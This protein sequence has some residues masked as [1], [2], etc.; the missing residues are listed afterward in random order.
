MTVPSPFDFGAVGNGT[1]DDTAALQSWIEVLNHAEYYNQVHFRSEETAIFR[2]S[3]ELWFYPDGNNGCLTLDLHSYTFKWDGGDG[4]AVNASLTFDSVVGTVTRGDAGDFVADGWVADR[5]F[6]V[7]EDDGSLNAGWYYIESVSAST[8]TIQGVVNGQAM[9]FVDETITTTIV[10]RKRGM[11]FGNIA[12]PDGDKKWFDL[13]IRG[14]RLVA[15]GAN[16]DRFI[17]LELEHA[18]FAGIDRGLVAIGGLNSYSIAVT[19]WSK[20]GS[21]NGVEVH[22]VRTGGGSTGVLVDNSNV[23][24]W[25]SGKIQQHDIGMRI[26]KCGILNLDTVDFSLNV[27]CNLRGTRIGGGHLRTIYAERIGD[28]TKGNTDALIHLDSCNGITIECCS[29]NG[30]NGAVGDGTHPAYGIY[31]ENCTAVTMSSLKGKLCQDAILYLDENCDYCVLEKTWNHEI[32]ADWNQRTLGPIL[33][34]SGRLENRAK[35]RG[36]TYVVPG[37]TNYIDPDVTTWTLANGAAFS[38][39]VESDDGTGTVSIL[40]LPN[41]AAAPT[42]SIERTGPMTSGVVGNTLVLQFKAKLVA[43]R[44]PDPTLRDTLLAAVRVIIY[45]GGSNSA[46]EGEVDIYRI[47]WQWDWYEVRYPNPS[48][49]DTFRCFLEGRVYQEP[50]DIAIEEFRLHIV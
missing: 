29:I 44:E 20:K 43:F 12:H 48:F 22:G 8:L 1:T 19:G 36:L 30:T 33:D 28:G 15:Y 14:I 47:G 35:G 39:T 2:F 42:S 50:I 9:S 11:T 45:G 49:D 37:S 18:D 46:A 10:D 26:R 16:P 41:V 21:C 3:E 38:G 6:E 13:T 31:L 25:T 7:L 34:M 17:G 24:T 32:G 23:F 27:V 5:W 4:R 40:E